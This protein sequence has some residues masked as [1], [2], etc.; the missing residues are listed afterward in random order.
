MGMSSCS[1]SYKKRCVQIILVNTASHTTPTVHSICSAATLSGNKPFITIQRSVSRTHL[2]TDFSFS[3][4][5]LGNCSLHGNDQSSRETT[6]VGKQLMLEAV[7]CL[8]GSSV[9]E[10]TRMEHLTGVPCGVPSFY[11]LHTNHKLCRHC[12]NTVYL[13]N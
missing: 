5:S 1:V 8:K 3:Q 11:L 9:A 2:V 6:V 13:R 10:R 4:L 7:C 12:G